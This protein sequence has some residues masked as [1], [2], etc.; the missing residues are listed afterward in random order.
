MKYRIELEEKDLRELVA[1]HLESVLTDGISQKDTFT[2]ELK[3]KQNYKS[4]WE[5]AEFRVVIQKG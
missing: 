5:P 3:S 4:E 1:E 2:I